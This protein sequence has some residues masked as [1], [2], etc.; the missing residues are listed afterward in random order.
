MPP[1]VISPLVLPILILILHI[2]PEHEVS[3][4]LLEQGRGDFLSSLNL[5]F[6]C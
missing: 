3:E 5:I 1:M 2:L 6:V 4:N